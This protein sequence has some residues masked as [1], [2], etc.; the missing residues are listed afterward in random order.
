MGYY[1]INCST[2][3]DLRYESLKHK[4]QQHNHKYF[5]LVI[6]LLLLIKFAAQNGGSKNTV[7]G[8]TCKT[9]PSVLSSRKYIIK[10]LFCY[11]LK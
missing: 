6:D 2:P 5:V 1:S 11:H 8:V 10:G 9:W 7:C 3:V 4:Q